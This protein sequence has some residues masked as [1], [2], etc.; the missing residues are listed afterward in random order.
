ML[1]GTSLHYKHMQTQRLSMKTTS[2]RQLHQPERQTE[3]SHLTSMDWTPSDSSSTQILF[4]RGPSMMTGASAG[5]GA[6]SSEGT[7]ASGLMSDAANAQCRLKVI[8]LGSRLLNIVKEALQANR[9]RLKTTRCLLI[10]RPVF[11]Y[12]CLI[13][14]QGATGHLRYWLKLFSIVLTFSYL[15]PSLC[16]CCQTAHCSETKLSFQSFST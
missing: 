13:E 5:V 15:F 16:L 11:I 6:S 8:L 12:C 9:R 10:S 3:T 14:A 2:E 7:A 1:F 4:S